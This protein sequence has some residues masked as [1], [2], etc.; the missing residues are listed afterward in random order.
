MGNT[1]LCH[2]DRSNCLL[3]KRG[4]EMVVKLAKKD[5]QTKSGLSRRKDLFKHAKEWEQNQQRDKQAS[6]GTARG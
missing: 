3:N 2:P 6:G 1:L 4:D 5:G